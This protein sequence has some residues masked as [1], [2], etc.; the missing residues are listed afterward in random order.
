GLL[1]RGVH[2]GISRTRNALELAHQVHRVEGVPVLDALAVADPE[3]VDLVDRVAIAGALE[4]HEHAGVPGAGREPRGDSVALGDEV[5]DHEL[6][7]GHAGPGALHAL[8]QA[9]AT[10][11][12]RAERVGDEVGRDQLVDRPILLVH[13]DAI[14]ELADDLLVPLERRSVGARFDWG[15]FNRRHGFLIARWGG[16]SGG[17]VPPRGFRYA[18]MA[19]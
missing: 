10:G 7:V 13:E 17:G 8:A 5:M 15:A 14:D 4:A 2:L 12:H 16:R 9:F 1:A 19:V 6:R 3:N 11:R 18:A